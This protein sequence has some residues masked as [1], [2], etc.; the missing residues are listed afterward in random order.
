LAGDP[1]RCLKQGVFEL[2][3]ALHPTME[4]PQMH[5]ISECRAVVG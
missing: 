1:Q 5:D 2:K 4:L 3:L